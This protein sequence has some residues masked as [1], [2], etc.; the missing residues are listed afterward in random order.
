MLRINFFFFIDGVSGQYFRLQ[1]GQLLFI[2]Q[3]AKRIID[4]FSFSSMPEIQFGQ[5]SIEGIR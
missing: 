5:R 4:S 3:P 2:S 1:F